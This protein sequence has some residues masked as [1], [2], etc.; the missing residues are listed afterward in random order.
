[1]SN[2]TKNFAANIKRIRKEKGLTQ[3]QLA[4]LICCSEKAVS[5]WECVASVPD[6]EVLLSISQKFY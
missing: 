6:I 1:M 3:K 4:E 5:K 2:I